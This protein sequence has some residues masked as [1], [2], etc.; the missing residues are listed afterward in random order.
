MA[1]EESKI[2]HET[3]IINKGVGKYV[4]ISTA[5]CK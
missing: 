1:P 5:L 2:L 3:N 4:R